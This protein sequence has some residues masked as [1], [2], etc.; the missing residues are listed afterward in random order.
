MMA[1]RQAGRQQHIWTTK[2]PAYVLFVR[3]VEFVLCCIVLC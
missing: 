3:G 1:G 2:L